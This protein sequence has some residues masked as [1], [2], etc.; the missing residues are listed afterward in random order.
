M[1]SLYDVSVPLFLRALRNLD[2]ILDQG[3][4]WAAEQG[5]PES[6][7]TEARLI[8]DMQPLTAQV[9][10]A[11]DAA[12]FV[13]ARIGG[14]EVPAM[15]D[16]EQTIAELKARIA[17]TIAVLDG[18]PRD[19]FDGKEDVPVEL[20][21]RRATMLF[22]ARSYLLDFALPN[23]FFHVTTAYA[24]LRQAGVPIGKMDYI[25]P[26]EVRDAA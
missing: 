7:L 26:V 4:A 5:R 11:S 9:Q 10:R 21:T 15:A 20:K 6:V 13:C 2:A 12:K 22:T 24:L 19:A 1:L 23:F 3:A 25:G 8:E 14:I 16:D 17:K 18:V